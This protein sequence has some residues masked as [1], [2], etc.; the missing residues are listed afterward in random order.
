AVRDRFVPGNW[1]LQALAAFYAISQ[2][3]S[4]F[5]TFVT[6]LQSARN[7]LGSAGKGFT[8]SDGLFKNHILFHCHP[9]LRLRVL[10]MPGLVYENIKSDGL[11]SL[12]SGTWDSMVAEGAIPRKLAVTTSGP[13]RALPTAT[14][15]GATFPKRYLSMDKE[16]IRAAGGCFKCGDTP[17]T[18]GWKPGH[19][20]YNCP[21]RTP[22]VVAAVLPSSSQVV[23]DESDDD[24]GLPSC[25][26][27]NGTDSEE[28]D[29]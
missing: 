1:K 7:A 28:S 22:Q 19:N 9:L 13:L 3:S 23:D 8:I 27:G 11:I 17:A 6:N 25:V 12:L 16:A 14:S 20:S 4:D 18:P 10:A 24:C 5:T 26:L 21:K 2:G 29:D 15:S